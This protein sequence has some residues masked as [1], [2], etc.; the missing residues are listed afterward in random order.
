MT[1]AATE[2]QKNVRGAGTG[3]TAHKGELVFEQPL[4]VTVLLRRSRGGT[5]IKEGPDVPDVGCWRGHDT[6]R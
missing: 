4:R 5:L 6:V 3:Q 2:V 1:I